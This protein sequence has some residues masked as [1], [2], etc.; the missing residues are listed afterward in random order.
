MVPGGQ[1]K[2]YN[3]NHPKPIKFTLTQIV[4]DEEETSFELTKGIEIGAGVEVG[5]DIGF[6]S[7]TVNVS[8]TLN[9]EDTKTQTAK[10]TLE[11]QMSGEVTVEKGEWGMAT[12]SVQGKQY[13][14]DWTV[15]MTPEFSNDLIMD[16]DFA[17]VFKKWKTEPGIGKYF[18]HRNLAIVCPG[19]DLNV[20]QK[21][22]M[23]GVAGL[24]FSMGITHGKL[25]LPPAKSD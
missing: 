18:A 14:G 24:A 23:Q 10:T 3:D 16:Q 6:A 17:D 25:P 15:N 20:T 4:I 12:V 9:F 19:I 13:A 7:A 11:Y 8:T 5:F 22:K 21:G 2:Y 1:F